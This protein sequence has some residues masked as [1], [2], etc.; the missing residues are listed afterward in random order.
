MALCLATSLL[1]SGGFDALDQMGR[2]L[3]WFRQG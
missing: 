1:E 2:Y 3:R